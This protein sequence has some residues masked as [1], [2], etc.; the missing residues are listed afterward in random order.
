MVPPFFNMVNKKLVD[1]A[2]FTFRLGNSEDDGGEVVFGDIDSSH[3]TGDI[4]YVPVRQKAYW[5]VELQKI[6][7][8]NEEVVLDSTGA[9]IDTGY[10]TPLSK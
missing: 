9:A 3:Y 7:F 4:T 1:K 8:G 6:K 5:E 10:Y 2:V